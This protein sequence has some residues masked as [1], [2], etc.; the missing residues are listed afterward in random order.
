MNKG[1]IRSIK[2]L[3]VSVEFDDDYPDIAEVLLAADGDDSPLMVDH[4]T[5]RG[6]VICLNVRGATTLQKGMAAVRTGKSIQIPVGTELIGRVVDANGRPVDGRPPIVAA[7]GKILEYRSIF[8]IPERSTSFAVTKPE[9]LETGIKVIDFFTP[10]VKGRKIGIIGGAGVGKT[11]L[12]MELINNV[13][14]SGAGMAFFAGI[15]ERIREGHELFQTLG[16]NDLL[17][18][19]CM[20][21]GQMDQN[22]VQRALI[23]LSAVTLAEYFRDEHKKDILFF[24][25]NMYRYIQARNELSTILDQIPA[26]GGYEPTLFSDVKLLQDRLS[27]N[28]HGSITAVQ[29]IYVPADDLSDPAVQMIQHELDGTL[30]LSRKVAEQGIRPSV[31]LLKTT[32][33]LLS[34]DIVGERHYVL[35]VQVQALLQKYESLKGIIAIIGENELSP[36]DRK[37]FAKARKLV[38]YFGQKMFV[39]EKLNGIPGEFVTREEMLTKIEEIII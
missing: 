20:F 4:V 2:G 3:V 21:F 5:E 29:T 35:S 28:Q 25:D 18:N 33:S 13:S 11:V 7:K 23:A 14:R 24:A 8:T 26:E 31:D 19:T 10:F 17:K 9:I 16:E 34:P 22:P 39:M 37:D 27:S 36:E 12:T 30:V 38:D 6:K 1:V 15:G 32:S